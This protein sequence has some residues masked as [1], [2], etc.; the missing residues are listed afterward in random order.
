DASDAKPVDLR[1]AAVYDPAGLYDNIVL[2]AYLPG[3]EWIRLTSL[4]GVE[5]KI[6]DGELQMALAI[7]GLHYTLYEKHNSIADASTNAAATDAMVRAVYQTTAML[8]AG[9]SPMQSAAILG[10][11]PEGEL[12]TVGKSF[13]QNY[14]LAYV[15]VF[16]LYMST[17]LYGQM[18][19][20]SVVTEKSSKAMELLITSAK[21]MSLMFGKVMGTGCAGLTQFGAF[22]LA[23]AATLS[24]NFG[25]WEAMSPMI[26]G[27]I[28]SAFSAGILVYAVV[29]F[30]LGFFSFAFIFAGLGS[31]VSRMEDAS[32]VNS[33]PMLLV[34]ATFLLAMSGLMVP[35]A[36]HVKICSFV[37]FLSPMIM[38]VRICMTEVPVYEII[39]ALALNCVYVLGSGYISSKIYRVGVMMYGNPPKLRDIIRYIRQA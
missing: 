21:P 14:W 33:V 9:L 34:V 28:N 13:F 39:I 19:L 18:I 30:L 8:E 17:V 20:T 29:F 11:A 25:G 5:Q 35:N 1:K 4:D 27:I 12:I 23:A 36:I 31:T 24:L 2:S 16:L 3:R 7:D 15:I 6:E 10:A 37:P 32:S 26:A 22:M 38:F